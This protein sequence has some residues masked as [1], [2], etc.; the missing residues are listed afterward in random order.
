MMLAIASWSFDVSSETFIRNHVRMIAPGET[1]I[2][3]QNEPRVSDL[4]VPTLLLCRRW[5]ERQPRILGWRLGNAVAAGLH[6]WVGLRLGAKD[7]HRI[8]AFFKR[9]RPSAVL[10]EYGPYGCLLWRIC[11]SC[12]VPLYVH[13]HGYDASLLLRDKRWV[14]RYRL[15]FRAAAGVVAPSKFLA[16]RLSGIGCPEA[17]L[18]I[19]PCGVDEKRLVPTRRLPQR[20]LSVGRLVEKKAPHVTIE[21]FAR[22]R[23]RFPKAELDMV[24]G[25]GPLADRCAT[26]IHDLGLGD[27]VRMHGVQTHEFVADLLQRASLFVQ[28]SVT[29]PDGDAEGLPVAILEAMSAALPVV[30][31]R[32]SGIPEAVEEGVTGLLVDEHDV[33]GMA[34]AMAQLLDDQGRAAAMGMAG[35]QRV[36]EHF[37]QEQARDRLRAM[38]GLSGIATATACAA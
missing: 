3:C 27:S 10:A 22:V 4:D 15:M 28:H 32:H 6:D 17:K 26:L 16:S 33:T 37:T 23:Q 20:I 31:T 14:R 18:H 5:W 8:R 19:I 25:E 35:R 9:Y 11:R 30:S 38:M 21:A 7:R 36:I 12:N 29:A 1:V 24:G 34:T 2:L 13:F